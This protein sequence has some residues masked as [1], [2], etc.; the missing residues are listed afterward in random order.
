M[1]KTYECSI[2]YVRSIGWVCGYARTIFRKITMNRKIQYSVQGD[3]EKWTERERWREREIKEQTEMEEKRKRD[4][5]KKDR[6]PQNIETI[7]EI[8]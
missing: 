4:K 7:P 5:E 8:E 2:I 3:M 6:Q 1:R